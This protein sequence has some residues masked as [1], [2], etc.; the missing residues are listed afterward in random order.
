MNEA[1]HG[2]DLLRFSPPICIVSRTLQL[3]K[4]DFT[5]HGTQRQTPIQNEDPQKEGW[6]IQQ[7]HGI[8]GR[9]S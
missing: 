8:T 5:K 2:H 3:P 1:L 7:Q 6:Q 4:P 9:E